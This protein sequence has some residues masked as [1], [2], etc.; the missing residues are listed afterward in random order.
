MQEGAES[1]AEVSITI[2][3]ADAEVSDLV[4]IL[5]AAEEGREGIA[6]RK[7][8]DFQSDEI[9]E[10]REEAMN[11]EVGSERAVKMQIFDRGE[12]DIRC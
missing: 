1:S 10:A 6:F 3:A 11:G 7:V 4:R 12:R 5:N 2:A 8:V 9:A